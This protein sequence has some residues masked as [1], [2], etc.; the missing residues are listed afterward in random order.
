VRASWSE[1]LRTATVEWVPPRSVA[2][3]MGSPRA[4]DAAPG[5]FAVVLTNAGD[6]K[7]ELVRQV[8]EL[9][10]SGIGEAMSLVEALPWVVRRTEDRREAEDLKRRLEVVGATVEL[11]ESF[12][13]K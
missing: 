8:R 2:G 11:T 1:L 7:I 10:G 6:R 4:I 5:G 12:R 9:T 13:A 3:E